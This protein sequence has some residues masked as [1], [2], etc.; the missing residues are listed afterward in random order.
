MS[1]RPATPMRRPRPQR[2]RSVR[3]ER[4]QAGLAWRL[5]TRGPTLVALVP[6]YTLGRTIYD[7]F[8]NRQFLEG[9]EPTE[10]VGLQ[11]YRDLLDDTI[12][13]DSV[14]VTVKFTAITVAFELVL[15]L[16]IALVVNSGFKG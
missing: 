7:S 8:T 13:R 1:T 14:V 6:I 10:F 11:N 16:V 3:L 2:W 9:L 4:K 5:P 12:F 15:G